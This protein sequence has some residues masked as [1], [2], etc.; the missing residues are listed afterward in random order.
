MDVKLDDVTS[1][2]SKLNPLFAERTIAPSKQS[3]SRPIEETT[4]LSLFPDEARSSSPS[5]EK[6]KLGVPTGTKVVIAASALTCVGIVV[7]LA[8]GGIQS[9]A[10]AA[11]QKSPIG[12]ELLMSI[13]NL[14]SLAHWRS[15]K[16]VVFDGY[17]SKLISPD[18]LWKRLNYD[19]VVFNLD[20][21]RVE[22][23]TKFSQTDTLS[24]DTEEGDECVVWRYFADQ[25]PE[26]FVC[27]SLVTVGSSYEVAERRYR[28]A[29]TEE[30]FYHGSKL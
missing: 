22:K 5:S 3:A 9:L 23:I 10:R 14:P 7:G 1:A 28:L 8:T 26:T 18:P 24:F 6:E 20:T 11:A 21:Q 25:K 17:R 2:I 29:T 19:R 27:K 30:L 15:K 16:A 12:K 13:A 4:D